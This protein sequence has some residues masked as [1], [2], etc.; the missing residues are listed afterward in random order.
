MRLACSIAFSAVNFPIEFSL[1]LT[2]FIA[3]FDF[4]FQKYRFFL[5]KILKS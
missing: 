5:L 3:P 2:F 4:G 1:V